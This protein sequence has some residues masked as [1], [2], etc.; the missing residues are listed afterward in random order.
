MASTASTSSRSSPQGIRPPSPPPPRRADHDTTAQATTPSGG[1]KS[2]KRVESQN[3]TSGG[4]RSSGPD[5]YRHCQTTGIENVVSRA[6]AT[7]PSRSSQIPSSTDSPPRYHL[8]RTGDWRRPPSSRTCCPRQS[9]PGL[10]A[11]ME[12][13]SWA[14]GSQLVYV[15][16]TVTKVPIISGMG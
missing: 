10:L 14:R 8:R 3:T 2:L 12:F 5:A 6:V 1:M 7:T 16:A 9:E 11:V 4:V 13:V 15:H